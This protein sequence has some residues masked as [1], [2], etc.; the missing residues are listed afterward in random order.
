MED[1]HTK[2]PE[3]VLAFFGVQETGLTPDQ[4]KKNQ[5]KY[6]YNGESESGSG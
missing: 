4:V 6:G 3:E 5:A 2:T 1:A